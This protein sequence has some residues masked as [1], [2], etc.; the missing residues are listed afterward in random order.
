M[1]VK[2][3]VKVKGWARDMRVVGQNLFIVSEDYGWR[4]GYWG[5]GGYGYG[6]ADGVAIAPGGYAPSAAKVVVSS[7]RLRNLGPRLAATKELDGYSGAFNVTSSEI[8][9]A[10]D[11][12]VDSGQG[13]MQPSGKSAVDYIA[14]SSVDGTIE[15][16]GTFQ[17]DGTF[18]N[19]SADNGRWNIDLDGN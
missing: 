15:P 8:L 14:F 6:G 11:V 1:Q 18:S 17:V 2:G 10:H 9:L 16:K 5:Y 4:Y 3:E 13:Y 19:W 7:V 12:L